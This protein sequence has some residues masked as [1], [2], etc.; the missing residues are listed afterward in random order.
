MTDYAGA[1]LRV[2]G[3]ILTAVV[4][5][6]AQAD[7]G[8]KFEVA[9]V[10]QNKDGGQMSGLTPLRSGDLVVFH[11]T[12]LYTLIYYAYHLTGSYQMVGF[13]GYGN[14]PASWFDVEARTGVAATDDQVRQMMR[15]VLEDRFKLKTHRETRNL[16]AYELVPGKGKPALAPASDKPMSVTIEGRTFTQLD[17][18]CGT[19]S[20][21]DGNHMVCHGAGMDKITD[22]LRSLL[23][24]PL[25]D[26][27]GLTGTYDLHLRYVPD[28]RAL[29]PSIEPGPSLAKAIQEDLG[30]VLQKAT[31]PVEVLVIDH[32]EKLSEN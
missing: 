9:S 29:D 8:L 32:V 21:T 18:A 11:N 4:T 22:Q 13:Q 26:R 16:P 27:T 3:V 30:L 19:S 24:S 6:S 10:K 7:A 17:G 15:S 31:A 12:Q 14:D 5:V 1:I 23:K 28:E 2:V 25:V 20:W